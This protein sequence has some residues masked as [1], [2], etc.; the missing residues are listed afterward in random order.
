MCFLKKQSDKC[1]KIIQKTVYNSICN[2]SQERSIKIYAASETGGVRLFMDKVWLLH[3][4][5]WLK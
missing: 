2:N 3:W 5:Y 1:T 4:D